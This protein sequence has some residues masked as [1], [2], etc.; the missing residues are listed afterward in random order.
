MVSRSAAK[1]LTLKTDRNS[2]DVMAL[3]ELLEKT[4]KRV[5]ETNTKV[6]NLTTD[7]AG[8]RTDV[9]SVQTDVTSLRTD[10][11][12]LDA[13]FEG[14]FDRLEALIMSPRTQEKLSG[15]D[16]LRTPQDK[17]LSVLETRLEVYNGRTSEHINEL[18]RHES[19][20]DAHDE[21]FDAHEKRFD[22]LDSQMA[23]V[24]GILRSKPA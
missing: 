12:N 19:M 20:F 10:L 14:R 8:L 4:D 16:A 7:V 21:R 11:G 23:E 13:K 5:E 1:E 24:L 15:S 2:E 22:H 17:R 3:Y 18:R 6:D 9:T